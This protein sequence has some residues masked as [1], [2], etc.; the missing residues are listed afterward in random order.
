MP[1]Y[2]RAAFIGE[3]IGSILAQT[4]G[5]WELIIID[6]GSDDDTEEVISRFKDQRIQFF[7]AGRIAINGKIKNIG[8]KKTNGQ[9]IAFIDSD[10]LWSET[11]LEK[12]VAALQ[13]YPEAGFSLTGGFNFTS[14]NQ[15]ID[16][17]YK[18]REGLRYGDIFISIFK[19]EISTT[20]PSLIFRKQCLDVVGGFDETKPFSD[21]DFI[22]KLASHFKA[23]ILYEPLLYRRLHQANDSGE[24]WVKG[25]QQGVSMIRVYKKELP[26]AVVHEALF[27]LY[28]NFGEDCLSHSQRQK[29]IK[30]FFLAWKNKPLSLVPAKKTGKALLQWMINYRANAGSLSGIDILASPWTRSD[31]PKRILA[32]RLQAMGDVTITLPYLQH[33]RN[34]LP[35]ST[36]MDFLT[37]KE[38]DDIPKNI[39]LFNKVIAIGGGRSFKKQLLHTLFLLPGFFLRRYDVVIDL[40]NNEISELVRKSIRPNAWSVFDRFS[41]RPAGERTRL[42]IEAIGLGRNEVSSDFKFRGQTDSAAILKKNGWTGTNELIVL[43]P[44]S[45]FITRSWPIE[46]YAAFAELWRKRFPNAQF[47]VIGTPLISA[48]ADYLKLT[49]GEK[50]ISIVNQTTPSQAFAILQHASFVLSEDSGLM[51]MAWVSGIPTLALFGSSRSDWTRPLGGKSFFLDSSD[52]PCGNCMQEVCRYGDVHCLTRYTPG[53]VFEKAMGIVSSIT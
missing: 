49:M 28:I 52:L 47:L 1:T 45:A 44:A 10:D 40:Q 13:E 31:L 37:R 7:K 25:Y 19:S 27:K 14:I 38:C 32:I 26:L 18:Q 29:A 41:S 39:L 3:T 34:S 2:N 20:T 4:Y 16:F 15:P 9:L 17:F 51:H 22:L 48:K 5:N 42:T 43:N 36:K 24:N 21:I 46:N 6:D 8:L 35:S 11:K 33:L 12:Q 53:F 30:K 23:V 50:I